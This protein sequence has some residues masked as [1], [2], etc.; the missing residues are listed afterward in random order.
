MSLGQVMD[1]PGVNGLILSGCTARDLVALR[2]A[3]KRNKEIVDKHDPV[4]PEINHAIKTLKSM[5]AQFGALRPKYLDKDVSIALITALITASLITLSVT[6]IFFCGHAPLCVALIPSICGV[7]GVSGVGGFFI[8]KHLI[9]EEWRYD[10]IDK[11]TTDIF[12]CQQEI[13]YCVSRLKEIYKQNIKPEERKKQ[14]EGELT[15]GKM[16][17]FRWTLWKTRIK[18]ILFQPCLL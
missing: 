15:F 17:R 18:M 3:S 6:L 11:F 9:V 4:R 5:S 12:W 10:A 2:A 14:F 1:I 8:V 13:G 7:G 16:C